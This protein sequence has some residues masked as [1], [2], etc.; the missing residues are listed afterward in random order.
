MQKTFK[1]TGIMVVA[2][3]FAV[4]ALIPTIAH[5]NEGERGQERV[6][7]L[8]ATAQQEKQEAEDKVTEVR[9]NAQE[10]SEDFKRR[11]DDAKQKVDDK[12]QSA[13]AR[14]EGKKLKACQKRE[15]NITSIMARMSDRGQK[16]LDVFTK[17]AE[18]TENFYV[19]KG[20]VLSNYEALVADVNAKKE[21]AT[22]AVAN[23]KNASINFAC[24]GDNPKAVTSTFKSLAQSQRDALKA[25]KTSVKNLIVGVKSV[26]ST[27]VGQSSGEQQ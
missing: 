17:I 2:L 22:A 24:N 16:Q 5:A 27:T 4:I 23:V 13:K 20:N 21:A 10:R 9:E 19:K 12:R 6:K 18:R 15:K 1:V 26:Q 14:L 25:Y 11:A 8:R 3:L 7:E